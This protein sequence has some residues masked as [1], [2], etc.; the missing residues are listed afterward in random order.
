MFKSAQICFW[1]F[2]SA[3][4]K[5]ALPSIGDFEQRVFAYFKNKSFRYRSFPSVVG[6]F[7]KL[8]VF[9]GQKQSFLCSKVLRFD[10]KQRFF[11]KVLRF[12]QNCLDLF[13][14]KSE[15]FEQKKLRF[16]T[17]GVWYFLKI[18]FW[19]FLAFENI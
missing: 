7:S 18:C 1:I 4:N 14:N 11:K 5:K 10:Q 8:Q 13:L 3:L 16:W 19:I 2:V 17:K 12:V 9:F 6:N 15:C